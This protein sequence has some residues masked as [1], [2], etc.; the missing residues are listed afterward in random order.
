MLRTYKLLFFRPNNSILPRSFKRNLKLNPIRHLALIMHWW[1]NRTFEVI[2]V[3]I[4][5]SVV[6]NVN[7]CGKYLRCIAKRTELS[8][9]ERI[10]AARTTYQIFLYIYNGIRTVF[11]K[12]KKTKN[13]I[14]NILKIQCKKQRF[15]SILCFYWISKLRVQSS[16]ITAIVPTSSCIHLTSFCHD[17]AFGDLKDKQIMRY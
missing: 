2:F 15:C 6:K 17:I 12:F 16:R 5:Y 10:N 4:F 3:L 14:L 11:D 1:I 7:K 8:S 9:N 13:Y